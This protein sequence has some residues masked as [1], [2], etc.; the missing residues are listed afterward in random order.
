MQPAHGSCSPFARGEVNELD[1]QVTESLDLFEFLSPP[2]R[3]ASLMEGGQVGALGGPAHIRLCP[4]LEKG[5]LL[6]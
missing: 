2:Q 5:N 4:S 6:A 1:T 3:D